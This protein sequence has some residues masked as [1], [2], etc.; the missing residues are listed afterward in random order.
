MTILF[1]LKAESH[2]D[3][4]SLTIK[5][6]RPRNSEFVFFN[7]ETKIHIKDIS[8]DFPTARKKA[9]LK[10]LLLH[11]LRHT[12]ASKMIEASVSLVTV[13]KILGHASIQ[14]T[15]RY[16]HPTPENMRRAVD[17]LGDILDTTRQ[18]VG[19]VEIPKPVSPSIL[20]N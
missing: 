1:V 18:K 9:D 4:K 10:G 5:V 2:I 3:R 20:Y 13:S 7:P 14:M 17:R 16:V 8:A 12:A 11:D 15:M 19:K 6:W